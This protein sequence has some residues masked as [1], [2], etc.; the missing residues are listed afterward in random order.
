V[1]KESVDEGSD[2]AK[3][4][5]REGVRR[6]LKSRKPGAF[7]PDRCPR[8]RQRTTN[9][10]GRC[11]V[12][13][14]EVGRAKTALRLARGEKAFSPHDGEGKGVSQDLFPVR[15]QGR[16]SSRIARPLTVSPEDVSWHSRQATDMYFG[17]NK[18]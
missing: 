5:E 12:L 16:S 14:A 18:V 6:A 1:S 7:S 4:G 10:G 13:P 3:C 17:L 9:S 8:Q 2:G 15:N 11:G